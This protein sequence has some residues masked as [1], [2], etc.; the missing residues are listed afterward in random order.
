MLE[1]KN[2]E[3]RIRMIIKGKVNF[4]YYDIFYVR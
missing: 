1:L 3:D 2:C 4:K